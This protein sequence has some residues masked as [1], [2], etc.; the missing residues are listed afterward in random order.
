MTTEIFGFICYTVQYSNVVKLIFKA[1]R[2]FKKLV[3]TLVKTSFN[4]V[5]TNLSL[6]HHL[7]AQ[8][9]VKLCAHVQRSIKNYMMCINKF[10]E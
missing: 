5:N 6:F 10:K 2:I 9:N 7:T 4:I 8:L 3:Y 1:Q